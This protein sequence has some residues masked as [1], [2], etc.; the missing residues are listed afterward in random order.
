VAYYALK[1]LISAVLIVAISEI[2]KRS[3]F[4]G[5]LIAS[6]PLVS[7]LAFVWLYVETKNPERIGALS[8]SIFW[9]VLPSLSLFI[10]LPYLLKKTENFYLSLGSSIAIMLALYAVMVLALRRWNIEL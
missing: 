7:I 5:G 8:Y 3:S 6:L 4:I 9:L 10:A 1:V 2:A